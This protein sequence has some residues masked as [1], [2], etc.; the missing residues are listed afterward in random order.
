MPCSHGKN[1]NE[2]LNFNLLSSLTTNLCAYLDTN[3]DDLWIVYRNLHCPFARINTRAGTQARF[4]SPFGINEPVTG[5]WSLNWL[6][7]NSN[8]MRGREV[9]W[10]IFRRAVIVS[11]EWK[12]GGQCGAL[13]GLASSVRSTTQSVSCRGLEC[14]PHGQSCW[15]TSVCPATRPW[16]WG[17]KRM[18]EKRAS[19]DENERGRRTE[20]PG[21]SVKAPSCFCLQQFQ[22]AATLMNP[23]IE[24]QGS[25]E[26]LKVTI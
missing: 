8:R 12:N 2:V 4:A 20:L 18:D 26:Q 22:E 24:D 16:C 14:W 6:A 11:C 25:C 17:D 19:V 3:W 7:G 9:D 1:L 10:W 21:A 13:Y 23:Q 15:P 5:D